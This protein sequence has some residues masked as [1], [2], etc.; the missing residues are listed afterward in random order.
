MDGG[1]QE[2]ELGADCGPPW[3]LR[4][5]AQFVTADPG[6]HTRGFPARFILPITHPTDCF[7]PRA[8]KFSKFSGSNWKS[9]ASSREVILDRI[10]LDSWNLHKSARSLRRRRACPSDAVF[11]ARE[12]ADVCFGL[13]AGS[14]GRRPFS[15]PEAGERA[16]RRP[17]SPQRSEEGQ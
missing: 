8:G 2:E 7:F 5:G 3:G 1:P 11:K 13:L 16:V 14:V 6:K 10:D 17:K 15:S 9:W 4:S 12:D